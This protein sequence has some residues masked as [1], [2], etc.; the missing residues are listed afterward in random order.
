MIGVAGAGARK[1][2]GELG[3]V[4]T[5]CIDKS[6]SAELS[7]AINSMFRWY[8]ESTRCYVYLS[9]VP[10]PK[11]PTSTVESAFLNSRR[12]KRAGHSKSS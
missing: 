12:F 2:L 6:S 10:N 9:D 11:D 7:E 1:G 4:N 5:C 3:W 8:R